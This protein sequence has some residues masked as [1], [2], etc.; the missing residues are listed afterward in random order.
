MVYSLG[1]AGQ[2]FVV[3][4]LLICVSGGTAKTCSLNYRGYDPYLYGCS[5]F[6]FF[7]SLV[8]SMGPVH[9]PQT[10]QEILVA[11]GHEPH[12][13][14]TKYSQQY[15]HAYTHE[16]VVSV[17]PSRPATISNIPSSPFPD[18]VWDCGILGFSL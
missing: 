15:I 13:Q 18:K 2:K 17:Y 5:T 16:I 4:P 12:T 9:D 14:S 8:Q 7:S 1:V 10:V 3:L 11:L 6:A